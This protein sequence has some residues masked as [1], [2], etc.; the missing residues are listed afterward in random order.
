M[1]IGLESKIVSR[2]L[3]NVSKKHKD[4]NRLDAIPRK[5]IIDNRKDAVQCSIDFTPET[6]YLRKENVA[7]AVYKKIQE[8]AASLYTGDN[9]LL[10]D[11]AER[12]QG[13]AA[14]NPRATKIEVRP[15]PEEEKESKET[16]N[17]Y[18]RLIAT[19]HETNHA[20]DHI[21]KKLRTAEEKVVSEIYSFATQA[22][23]TFDI[24]D[25]P[26][27]ERFDDDLFSFAMELKGSDDSSFNGF[28]KGNGM[29]RTIESYL[30]LYGLDM[31]AEQFCTRH[32]DEIKKAFELY[33]HLIGREIE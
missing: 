5:K 11:E 3:S 22:A 17:Y 9:S 7:S 4:T 32:K 10:I 8:V 16:K 12:Q 26:H 15:L 31:T 30:N 6:D 28:E 24:V 14:F 13:I 18:D 1:K 2:V 27:D 21:K 33:Y 23:V 29:Y 19:S 25:K 20:I